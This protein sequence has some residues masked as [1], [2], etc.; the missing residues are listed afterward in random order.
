MNTGRLQQEAIRA[1]IEE[2][3]RQVKI[4]SSRVRR[5]RT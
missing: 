4:K 1:R 3:L 5:W 2:K